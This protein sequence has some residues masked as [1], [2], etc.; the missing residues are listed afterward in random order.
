MLGLGYDAFIAY[1]LTI[2]LPKNI[3]YLLPQSL[4]LF[5]VLKA[6]ANP[7][8]HMNLIDEKVKANFSFF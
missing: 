1:M 6:I 4:L 3:V 5:F 8:Y 2:S 7:L